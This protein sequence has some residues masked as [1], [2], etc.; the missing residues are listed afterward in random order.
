MDQQ[1]A[2]RGGPQGLDYTLAGFAVLALLWAGVCRTEGLVPADPLYGY[3]RSAGIRLIVGCGLGADLVVIASVTRWHILGRG[4]RV[5]LRVLAV[6]AAVA[7]ASAWLEIWYGSKLD[8]DPVRYMEQP[9]FSANNIGAAGSLVLLSYLVWRL[10]LRTARPRVVTA[11]RSAATFLL[12]V[13]HYVA[14]HLLN[15][16]WKLF[17]D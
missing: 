4:R 10:P 6:S 7:A 14:L 1:R 5:L 3:Y 12:I 17:L 2:N 16:P 11:G 13:S 9:A 15:G 8:Y